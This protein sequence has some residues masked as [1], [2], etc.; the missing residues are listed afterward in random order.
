M[1]CVQPLLDFKFLNS[2][3]ECSGHGPFP[4]IQVNT[5]IFFKFPSTHFPAETMFQYL[6]PLCIVLVCN[7]EYMAL[8]L[9][10]MRHVIYVQVQECASA[11]Q[12][13]LESSSFYYSFFKPYVTQHRWRY[14]IRCILDFTDYIKNLEFTIPFISGDESWDPHE[15]RKFWDSET[16]LQYVLGYGYT[17]YT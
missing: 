5:T 3:Y 13:P 9:S 2:T 16:A 8:L 11:Y 6:P 17:L 7:L 10:L 4:F 14:T 12:R 1:S 15:H